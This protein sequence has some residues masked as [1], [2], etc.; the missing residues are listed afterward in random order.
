[1]KMPQ[2][3][4]SAQE[5][6]ANHP[7]LSS[8]QEGFSRVF[9]LKP[10]DVHGCFLARSFFERSKQQT[11][12]RSQQRSL[13]KA[14]PRLR[15]ARSVFESNKQQTMSHLQ[16]C[17]LAKAF[18]RLNSSVGP[19]RAISSST[20]TNK[21][22]HAY[23]QCNLA[24][25]FPRLRSAQFLLRPQQATNP[26]SSTAAWSCESISDAKLTP[27]KGEVRGKDLIVLS[28]THIVYSNVVLWK[29]LR[30]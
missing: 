16:Q 22:C 4:V 14:F 2:P 24:K 26:T 21:P 30:N 18:P 1:M 8:R 12:S 10:I 5:G 17:S 11:M 6:A 25:A 20:A 27:P 23:Q 15:S 9:C 7:V 29:Y 28:K 19:S 13:A 3:G